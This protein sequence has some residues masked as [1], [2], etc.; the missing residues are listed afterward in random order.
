MKTVPLAALIALVAGT[1]GFVPYCAAEEDGVALAIIYDTSG[2]M[3]D[4]VPDKS[5]GSSPKYVIA[6]RALSSVAR[7]IQAFAT[8]TNSGAP[9]KINTGLFVFQGEHGREA[10]KMGPFDPAAFQDFAQNFSN[11]S[12]NTPLG[13][14]LTTACR[15][16]LAS[17]LSR[18]HVLVI[19]D[20]INTAGL[21]PATVLPGLKKQAEQQGAN[22]G[23]HFIAFDVDAK[24][25]SPLKKLGAT[26]V[27][28]ADENQLNTQLQYI[29]QRKILLEDEEPKK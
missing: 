22:L 7:Q 16:V 5:G 23:V 11:P 2:S 8:N 26:V 25:F 24:V 18:K 10:I 27:S 19:T 20:G 6:N 28:A 4:P 14:T 9:R 1:P 13:N 21:P 12:G 17:P 15:T 29:L 3:K